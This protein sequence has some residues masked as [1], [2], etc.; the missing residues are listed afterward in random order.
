MNVLQQQST[1]EYIMQQPEGRSLLNNAMLHV[2]HLLAV[3]PAFAARTLWISRATG[4]DIETVSFA[5]ASGGLNWVD[6]AERVRGTVVPVASCGFCGST[7]GHYAVGENVFI[8]GRN[9]GRESTVFDY[10]CSKSKTLVL[11]ARNP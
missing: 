2:R 10:H 9:G 11:D 8:F 1:P 5:S 6:A 4:V 3:I 7:S